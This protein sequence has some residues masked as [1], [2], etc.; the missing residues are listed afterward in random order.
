MDAN[1]IAVTGMGVVTPVGIGVE[2]YWNA[3]LAG[4]CGVGRITRFD[5]EALAVKIAAEVR[6]FRPEDFLPRRL[7]S[8]TDSFTQFAYAAAE[9]A[10]G[11]GGLPAAPERCGIVMGTAMAG[12]ATTAATQEMLTCAVHKNVGPRFVPRILANIAAGQIAIARNIRGPSL[13]ISTAC[14]SGGDAIS[15]AARPPRAGDA[16]AVRL[17][18]AEPILCP[19]VIYA[20][21]NAQVLSRANDTPEL[22]CRPFDRQRSGFVI[23]EGGG[24]LLL[25][26]AAHATARGAEILGELAGWANNSDAHHVTDPEPNGERAADCMRAALSR[27]RMAAADIGYINAHGTGTRAG[28]AAEAEAVRRV[29]GTGDG[30]PRVSSTKGATGHMMGAGGVTEAI[31]CLLA[32]QRGALPP[33]LNLEQPDAP[34]NLVARTAERRQIAAAMSNAFGF[35]GQNSSLVFRRV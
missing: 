13:T 7:I 18:G 34:L 26:T 11:P 33:T 4:R 1:A 30:A 8:Q 12:I 10:L 3:L 22:A 2:D 15:S 27:A 32:L 35:G 16:A 25:E 19:L 14:A 29:F 24:A 17:A 23:G 28:D 21:A 9:Q 20:L 6:D 31:A 5:A